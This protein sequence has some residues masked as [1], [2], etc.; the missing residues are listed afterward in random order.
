VPANDGPGDQSGQEVYYPPPE[1]KGGWRALVSANAAP[2]P[3]QKRKILQT[4]GLDWDKL[5]EVWKYCASF[6]GPNSLLVVRRGWVAGEWHNFTNPRGIASCTKSLTAVAMAKLLDL[7]DA[8]KLTR[9][10]GIEDEAWRYLPARWA[11]AEPARKRIQLRHLLTMT[12]GLTPY[13]GPYQADYEDKVFAQA[14]E[15][16]PGTVWAY[17]SVP[18]DMLSLVIEN[19]TGRTQEEFF[20]EHLGAAIGAA[21]VTWGKFNRHTGGSGGPE[22]GARFPARELARVGFL[23]LRDGAWEKDG[24]QDQVL[25]AARVREFTRWA[26]FL[27]KATWRRPNFAWEPNANLFYGHLWWNNR[28]G[29]ALGQAVPRDAVYMSGWGKQACF[30][31][32]SLDLVVV[33]LGPERKLNEHPD[34]Y[35]EL[36]SRLMAALKD[37]RPR[38]VEKLTPATPPGQTAPAAAAERWDD[39]ELA[40]E[41]DRNHSNPF[42]RR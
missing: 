5:H 13:D 25:S 22:G 32:P 23:V 41:S 39:G 21:P 14:V 29:Q 36:W 34:Y 38:G 9:R 28:T 37:A 16:P 1:N 8:G 12:S 42:P 40:L 17:A 35:R 3:E 10:V 31:V 30:V 15:A 19:V 26:P 11:E 4:A 18:V 33:R 2:T 24:K 7:S 20:N 27:E 6:G